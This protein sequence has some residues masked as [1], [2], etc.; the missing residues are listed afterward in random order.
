MATITKWEINI[1]SRHGDPWKAS[2]SDTLKPKK[3]LV[4][5]ATTTVT[6]TATTVANITNTLKATGINR[7]I[8]EVS[9]ARAIRYLQQLN[10]VD[11]W[12]LRSG[13]YVEDIV[14]K[15]IED[16]SYDYPCISCILDLEDPIWQEYFTRGVCEEIKAYNVVQLPVIEDDVQAYINYY[17]NNDSSTAGDYYD[18]ASKQILKFSSSYKK[19]WMKDSIVNAGEQFGVR[20]SLDLNDF[21]EGDLLHFHWVFVYRAF[22]NSEVKAKLGEGTSTSSALGRNEGRSVELTERRERKNVGAKVDI[23]FEKINHQVG[24]AEAGKHDVLH[25][26][27]KTSMMEWSSCR[28]LRKACCACLLV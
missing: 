22:R 3:K 23:L 14:L 8:N 5:S 10:T 13:N 18:F 25:I 17:D 16:S 9:K 6:T 4:S 11:K 1:E 12:K 28:K 7:A 21:S 24:C 20:E 15:A 19:L 2:V 27:D 26:D